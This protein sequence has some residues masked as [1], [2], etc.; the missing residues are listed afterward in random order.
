[1]RNLYAIFFLLLASFGAHGQ[2]RIL[3][4][5]LSLDKGV[6]ELEFRQ[7]FTSVSIKGAVSFDSLLINIDGFE[8]PVLPAHDEID[9]VV[10]SLTMPDKP[11]NSIALEYLGVLPIEILLQCYDGRH[12]NID[13][14]AGVRKRDEC[15]LPSL[16]PQD[17]WRKDLPEPAPNPTQTEVSH[18][19]IHH[20]AT[21]NTASD[22]VQVVRNIYLYHVNSNGWD[23]VGYNYLIAPDGTLFAGRDGQ[24]KEGDNIKGAHFCGK[25]SNTMGVCLLGNF[26]EIPPS[27][28]MLGTL[29]ELLAWKILKEGLQPLEKDF[30]PKGSASGFNLPVISGHRDGHKDGVF[31][32]CKTECPGNYTYDWLPKVREEVSLKLQS[33]DYIVNIHETA[34]RQIPIS[35]SRNG[36]RVDGIENLEIL[37]YTGRTIQTLSGITSQ[38]IALNRGV[39]LIRGFMEGNPL[40]QVVVIP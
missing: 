28:T 24:G 37:D 4:Y 12:D 23:D 20:S 35:V 10:S 14:T 34:F 27:D 38:R 22:Y 40:R 2:Q 39:Y 33:C 31:E 9:G 3:E 21:S 13:I 5:P 16:I 36:L 30:H 11:F 6:T 32:G 26:S 1:M 25:N 19:I 18:L 17:V 8:Y 7:L 15:D 29:V